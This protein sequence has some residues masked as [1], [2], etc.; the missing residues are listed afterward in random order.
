MA[1]S[2]NMS[3]MNDIREAI[4]L[5]ESELEQSRA[6]ILHPGTVVDDKNWFI[7]KGRQAASR[8][9]AFYTFSEDSSLDLCTEHISVTLLPL[10]LTGEGEI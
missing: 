10:T 4:N 6:G 5:C 1:T 3:L 2:D 7:A 8:M 9:E